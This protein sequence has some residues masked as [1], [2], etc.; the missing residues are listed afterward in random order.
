MAERIHIGSLIKQTLDERGQSYSWLA[1]QIYTDVSNVPK[2]LKRKSISTDLLMR[3]SLAMHTNFFLY[4]NDF[5]ARNEQRNE[6]WPA[7]SL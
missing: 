6:K 7:G 5:Y 3:I 2:I 4:F 1:R